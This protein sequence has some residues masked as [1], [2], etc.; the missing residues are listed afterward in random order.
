MKK[1]LYGLAMLA[2]AVASLP[3]TAQNLPYAPPAMGG[4]TSTDGVTWDF[5]QLTRPNPPA[6]GALEYGTIIISPSVTGSFFFAQATRSNP[7]VDML[8]ATQ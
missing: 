1:I 3:M 5:Q 2:A 4:Y 8:N 6:I 7:F